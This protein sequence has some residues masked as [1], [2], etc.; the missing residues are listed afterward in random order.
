MI[1]KSGKV[2]HHYNTKHNS[3]E[4]TYR[5]TSEMKA[6]NMDIEYKYCLDIIQFYSFFILF[7]NQLMTT[8]RC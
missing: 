2:K 6:Q 8:Y 3:F 7:D 4:Q 5:H 1:I